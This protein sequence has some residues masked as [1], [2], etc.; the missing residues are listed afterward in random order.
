MKS[1][2][3]SN[4]TVKSPAR[5]GR[6]LL[7]GLILWSLPLL[8]QSGYEHVIHD[9]SGGGRITGGGYASLSIIGTGFG[10]QVSTSYRSNSGPGPKL[11]DRLGLSIGPANTKLVAVDDEYALDEGGVLNGNR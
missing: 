9:A 5:V 4:P 11:F 8:G 1:S 10:N 2:D 7:A 6:S 3:S